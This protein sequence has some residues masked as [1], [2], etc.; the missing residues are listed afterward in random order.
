M[1]RL[2]EPGE[3]FDFRIHPEKHIQSVGGC[4][5]LLMR[6]IDYDNTKVA[7]K[8]SQKP[9]PQLF[10]QNGGFYFFRGN[11]NLC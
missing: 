4:G 3:E 1:C 5:F 7:A 10:P 9:K 6:I 2:K 8:E 11:S